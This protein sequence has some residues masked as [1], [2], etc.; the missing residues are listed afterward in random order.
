MITSLSISNLINILFIAAGVGICGMSFLQVSAGMHI[1]DEVKKY[2]KLFFTLINIYI[3]MHLIRMLMEGRTGAFYYYGIRAVTFTEFLVS[4]FMI[5][6]LS[7]LILFI[8]DPGKSAKVIHRI[9]LVLIIIHSAGL[10]IAQF[11]HFY[12]YFDEFN[13]YHRSPGY[14]ASNVMHILML[15]QNIF[16]LVRNR[17]KFDRRLFSALWIYLLSPLGAI[18][19][20]ILTPDIQ[21]IILVTVISAAYLC[22]VIIKIQTEKY[23]NQQKE[24]HRLD[25]ELMMATRIQAETLPSIFPAFPD[26]NEFNIYASMNPAKEVGG[27]FYDFFL[28]DEKHLGLVIA[29][30]SGKGIPAALFMMVS[31]ILI[32]NCAMLGHSPEKVLEIVNQQICSNNPERMFVTVWYGC[33]NL[34]TGDLVAANAG[35]EY[36][37]LKNANGHFSLIK[38]KHGIVIGAMEGKKYRQYE[39]HMEPGS[40]LFI[41]TDGIP[42]AT[43]AQNELF[44]T[45][46]LV[47]ALRTAEDESPKDILNK[48]NTVVDEFVK[49][50]PQF[51]DMTMLCIEFKGLSGN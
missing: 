1:R 3:C 9:F 31:K 51:D 4:G 35:H 48:V 19:V 26:R 50:A 38:D 36:P 18:A 21:Y 7:L 40:K 41:Y 29:D 25:N 10:L 5:Y 43:N 16:L 13:I 22:Y 37:I 6:M 27:D 42:E 20:Q 44:G 11:T 12:Y 47:Q 2:F 28:L 23:E 39:L 14:A 17:S 24:K 15:C 46:R 32:Q 8:A 30:V 45:D 34:E 33:L 49:D